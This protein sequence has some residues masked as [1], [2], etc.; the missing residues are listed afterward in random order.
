MDTTNFTTAYELTLKLLDL[1]PTINLCSHGPK[2]RW[3]DLAYLWL[4]KEDVLGCNIL[5]AAIHK[6][7]WGRYPDNVKDE[8]LKKIL[9]I[10]ETELL[11]ASNAFSVWKHHLNYRWAFDYIVRHSNKSDCKRGPRHHSMAT[12]R[13]LYCRAFNLIVYKDKKPPVLDLVTDSSARIRSVRAHAQI[14]AYAYGYECVIKRLLPQASNWSY[15]EWSDD[16]VLFAA[17]KKKYGFD[18]SKDSDNFD[19]LIDFLM[20]EWAYGVKNTLGKAIMIQ[21]LPSSLI[22]TIWPNDTLDHVTSMY[23]TAYRRTKSVEGRMRRDRLGRPVE[24][25][26]TFSYDRLRGSWLHQQILLWIY[27]GVSVDKSVKQAAMEIGMNV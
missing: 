16:R 19:A 10:V 26:P 21:E 2:R 6:L 23:L 7:Y 13:Y 27:G 24:A 1:P 20:N 9:L 17:L 11:S 12:A 14:R 8:D 25:K 3:L 4:S 22:S 18:F 5:Y 15:E